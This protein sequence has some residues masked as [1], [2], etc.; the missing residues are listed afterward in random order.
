MIFELFSHR[1]RKAEA[2]AA[3]VYQYEDVPIKLRV[4]MQQLMREAIGPQYRSN[5]YGFDSPTHNPEMWEIVHGTLCRELG[6]HNLGRD[7]LPIEQVM[8]FIEVCEPDEFVDVI[9]LCARVVSRVLQPMTEYDRQKLGVKQK[10]ED[11]ISEINY[12]FREAC[13]GYQFENGTAFRVDSEF[14]H[15]ELVKPTL[16]ILSGQGYD[17]AR[18]EFLEAHRHYRAG[19]YEQAII[20]AA[21]AFESTLKIVCEQ[22]HWP[23]EKGARSSDLLKIVRSNGLWPDYLDASFDQLLATLTSG[24]PKVRN[25]QS[26]HG[27]GS[28]VRTTPRHVAA[29]AIH[30]AATKIVFVSDAA[31][32]SE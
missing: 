7:G 4:Q 19:D 10:P 16:R 12:R 31:L 15:E 21:K 32:A 5:D 2:R 14:M 25:E 26:A 11:A 13:F 18:Q 8:H 17:G 24:L 28:A 27:Q 6:I 20:E 1:K 29:Y 9:E 23:F 22:K 3:D 30:L